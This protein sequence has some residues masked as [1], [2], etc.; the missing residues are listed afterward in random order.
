LEQRLAYWIVAL[1]QINGK[2]IVLE[3]RQ[4]DMYTVFG[5]PRQSLIAALD[6]LQ[7]QGI[8]EYSPQMIKVL[9]RRS[10]VEL[11]SL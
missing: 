4:K 2:D 5:V 3:C 10:L 9:D 8:I 7:K 1:T 11:L 6:N